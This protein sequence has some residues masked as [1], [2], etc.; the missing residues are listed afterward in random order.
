[1]IKGYNIIALAGPILTLLSIALISIIS[2]RKKSEPVEEIFV[3]GLFIISLWFAFA[4]TVH[5]WYITMPLALVLFTNYRYVFVW[6]FTAF[7]SYAAYQFN[8]V[9]EV[10][11]LVAIGYVAVF[12]FALWE[13]IKHQRKKSEVLP[14]A[15]T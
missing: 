10:L 2:F 14:A 3:K 8:P 13:V 7:L 4:T 6:S 5:P 12:T 1:L 15:T 11:W 9:R